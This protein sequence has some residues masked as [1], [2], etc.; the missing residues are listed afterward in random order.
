MGARNVLITLENGCF[1]LVRAGR[2]TKRIRAFA[3]H[4]EPLSGVGSGDVLL[5]QYLAAL[6]DERSPDYAVRLAVAAGAASVR[7]VGA[8]RF[9]P[10]LAATMAADIELAE[11]QPVRS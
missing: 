2:K 8:G 11:L 9:D 6:V 4:V 3:P 5:A 1:A 10:A 7:E